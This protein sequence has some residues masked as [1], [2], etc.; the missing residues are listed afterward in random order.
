MKKKCFGK[1]FKISRS[2]I[3]AAILFVLTVLAVSAWYVTVTYRLT[4]TDELDIDMP[5]IIYIK[6]DNLQEITSFHLDGL[7]IGEPYNTVFCVSPAVP[8]SVNDFFLGVIYTENLGMNISLY[9]V[10]SVTE[11]EIEDMLS[12]RREI[13]S[14][15]GAGNNTFFF[16]YK[17][18]QNGISEDDIDAYTFKETYGDWE[19]EIKPGPGNL[20]NG[21]YKAYRNLHFSETATGSGTLIDKLNDKRQY[22]FFILSITW[23]E[24][25]GVENAKETDIVY[26]V[27]KGSLKNG[28]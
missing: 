5:P 18:S 17:T 7:K 21:I 25:N 20:N 4:R 26:I 13:S 15:E 8:G 1:V 22:R 24:N 27:S 19:N 28:T 6:D 10:S 9:P 12:V 11:G 3:C 2:A 14:D 16:N 23:N